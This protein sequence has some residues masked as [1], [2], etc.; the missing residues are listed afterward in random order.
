MRA[1]V[2]RAPTE[3][4]EW[5][6]GGREGKYIGASAARIWVTE[7]GDVTTVTVRKVIFFEVK[8]FEY[9]NSYLWKV[10]IF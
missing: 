4:M 3:M 8:Y 2:T 6:G 7:T 10:L 9:L 1:S 5:S